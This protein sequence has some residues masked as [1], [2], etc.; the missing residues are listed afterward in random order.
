MAN[1]IS[2]GTSVPRYEFKQRDMIKFMERVYQLDPVE[3]RRLAFMYLQSDID[4][5]HTVIKDY[6]HTEEAAW[7][8]LQKDSD[9]KLSLPDLDARMA[10]YE[11]EALPL[12]LAS[13]ENCIKDHLDK[14]E[15]THLITVSCTGM[16]APGLDLQIAE[17]M[18]LSP[19]I[20]R[21][22]I[23]FMGCYAAVHALKLAKYICDSS[24]KANVLIVAT[25][26][27][28]IH[29]QKE[30][31][32]DYAAGALL[33]SD[34]SAS[35]LISNQLP[36]PKKLRLKDFYSKVVYQGSRDMAWNISTKGFL[37]AL[38]TYVPNLVEQNVIALVNKALEKF[39]VTKEAITHWC[40]HPG[41]KKV[42]NAVRD[43]LLLTKEQMQYARQVLSQYG[44]MSC[45]SVL[46]VLKNIM[47]AMGNNEPAKIFGVALGPGLTMESF[48][49]SREAT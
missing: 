35:V 26:L 27:C 42:L 18:Q 7:E 19:E 17:A 2:I 21:T 38:S 22:S 37:I 29:F 20:S 39:R 8:F 10:I 13:I 30:Y 12:S 49:V 1:I 34:G 44:N 40:L 3:Q 11:K 33:F 48:Y 23:N 6:G 31:T 15:I 47:D 36:S 46:F 25:E 4:T 16:S 5:R 14:K 24:E 45:P 28:S 41:G 32:P 43:E 9:G